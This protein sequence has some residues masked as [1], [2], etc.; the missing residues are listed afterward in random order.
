MGL[1]AENDLQLASFARTARSRQPTLSGVPLGGRRSSRRAR[2]ARQ[3]FPERRAG[4]TP[5]SRL[6][7]VRSG[8]RDTPLFHRSR[9]VQ[10][11]RMQNKTLRRHLPELNSG[12]V[13]RLLKRLRTHGLIKKIGRTYKY[14]ATAFGKQA[15]AT[16]LKLR[17]LV[18]IPQLAF[19]PAR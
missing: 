9:R 12:Q 3:T 14:Y 5:L 16:A 7:R 10:H 19:A 15:V 18:I 17:E 11:Q 6:Q 8:R 13:S 4:R 2:Q 1:H